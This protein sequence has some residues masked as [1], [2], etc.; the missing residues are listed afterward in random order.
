MIYPKG[1]QL[2]DIKS[3]VMFSFPYVD[4]D[5]DRYIIGKVNTRNRGMNLKKPFALLYP[6]SL[7]PQLFYQN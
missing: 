4:S 6:N 7:T 2:R 3:C 1:K 5:L